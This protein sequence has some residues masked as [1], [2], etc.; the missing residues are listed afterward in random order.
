MHELRCWETEAI[1]RY[2]LRDAC[3]LSCMQ[4]ACFAL[5]SWYVDVFVSES[6]IP[7]V[8]KKSGEEQ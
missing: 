7:L 6:C 5:S 8:Q 1:A 2:E 3:A 4:C